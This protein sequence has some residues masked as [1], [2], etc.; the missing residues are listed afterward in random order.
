M[1]QAKA[2]PTLNPVQGLSSDGS[3]SGTFHFWAG[4]VKAELALNP[5]QGLKVAGDKK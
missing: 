3:K 1:E 5:V 2:G 4:Q